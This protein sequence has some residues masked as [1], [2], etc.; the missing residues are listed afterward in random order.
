MH[1][2]R[3]PSVGLCFRCTEGLGHRDRSYR[4]TGRCFPGPGPGS[5]GPPTRPSAPRGAA[6]CLCRRRLQETL[7]LFRG[8]RLGGLWGGRAAFTLRRPLLLC[9]ELAASE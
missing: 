9:A 3:E 1:V 4:E 5:L 2:H 8:Q 6:P 7:Q